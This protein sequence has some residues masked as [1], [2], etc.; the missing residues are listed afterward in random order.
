MSASLIMRMFVVCEG[1]RWPGASGASC[2]W[3]RDDL[4]GV[5]SLVCSVVTSVTAVEVSLPSD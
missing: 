1:A 5:V 3:W 4:Q 2:S